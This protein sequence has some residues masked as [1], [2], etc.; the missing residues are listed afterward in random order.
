MLAAIAL[1]LV[2][3]L[4]RFSQPVVHEL[5]EVGSTRNFVPLED[6]ALARAVPGLLI[7]RPEEPLFFASAERAVA[8]VMHR[9]QQKQ[10]VHT[11][12]LSL[13]ESS[14]L[15]STAV[16]CLL[17]LHQ[18]LQKSGIHLVLAR[19][20]A[21]VRELFRHCDPQGLGQADHLHLSV[22]DAAWACQLRTSG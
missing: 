16:E 4:K 8:D 1:S 19:V 21:P 20:K 3:A 11:V 22:A 14:D 6:N 2:V 18:R 7:L 17:E 9:T 5:G 10:A 15:D 13:E 12:I